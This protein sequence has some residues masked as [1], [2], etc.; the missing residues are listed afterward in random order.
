MARTPAD[1]H[2]RY[3]RTVTAMTDAD[4]CYLRR[5]DV[6]GLGV[7]YPELERELDRFAT[8]RHR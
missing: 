4:L 3:D 5:D 2:W 1:V 7:E 8:L 6:I